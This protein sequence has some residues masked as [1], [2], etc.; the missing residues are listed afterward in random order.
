M[1]DDEARQKFRLRSRK[2]QFFSQVLEDKPPFGG[3]AVEVGLTFPVPVAFRGLAG[4]VKEDSQ[5]DKRRPVAPFDE[6]R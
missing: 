4:V 1:V 3:M 6:S 5:F 2:A